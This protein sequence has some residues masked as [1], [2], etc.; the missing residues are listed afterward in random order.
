MIMGPHQA[1]GNNPRS[2]EFAYSWITAAIRYVEDHRITYAEAS[3][4]GVDK[5]TQRKWPEGH[6]LY[7]ILTCNSYVRRPRLRRRITRRRNRF[8]DDRHQPQRW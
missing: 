6:R 7:G 5:W 1:Y 8:M 2:I 3:Q 4:Q